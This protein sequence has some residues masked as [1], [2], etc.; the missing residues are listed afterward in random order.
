MHET[1]HHTVAV[2]QRPA[3]F[4]APAVH[5]P[6]HDRRAAER[7]LFG[8]LLRWNLYYGFAV[9]RDSNFMRLQESPGQ[10]V[11][12]HLKAVGCKEERGKIMWKYP[13]GALKLDFDAFCR[14]CIRLADRQT[15]ASY[16]TEL[17][18]EIQR[19]VEKVKSGLVWP[20]AAS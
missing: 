3:G 12:Q 9:V 8:Q 4:L 19:E 7:A 10:E 20:P 1:R 18:S 14:G 16:I 15:R 6:L 5:F 2:A 17:V 13:S 11:F